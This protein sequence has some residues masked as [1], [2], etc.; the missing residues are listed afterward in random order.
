M[1]PR[2][3]PIT[4]A[5]GDG[6]R[7]NVDGDPSLCYVAAVAWTGSSH[8][9]DIDV[10]GRMKSLGTHRLTRST[11]ASY[12]ATTTLDLALSRAKRVKSF[13][14]YPVARVTP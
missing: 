8:R 4:F 3:M 13:V 1:L 9:F 10:H 12:N 6:H 7:R 14:F 2:A 11:N 5:A